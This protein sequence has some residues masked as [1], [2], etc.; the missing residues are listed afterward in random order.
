MCIAIR[1]YTTCCQMNSNQ[2]YVFSLIGSSS[3]PGLF[4]QSGQFLSL[5]RP[6]VLAVNLGKI[7]WKWTA[8]IHCSAKTLYNLPL[9]YAFTHALTH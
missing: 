6:C 5:E 8:I 2:I 3:S 7:E 1:R 9:S 4:V